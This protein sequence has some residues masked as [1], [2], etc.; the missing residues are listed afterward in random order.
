MFSALVLVMRNTDAICI[1]NPVIRVNTDLIESRNA[2]NS[3]ENKINLTTFSLQTLWFQIAFPWHFIRTACTVNNSNASND[4]KNELFKKSIII[5]L[6]SRNFI[7]FFFL[8]KLFVKLFKNNFNSM[9]LYK[10]LEAI[11]NVNWEKKLHVLKIGLNQVRCTLSKRKPGL[12]YIPYIINWL[13]KH[14]YLI[15]SSNYQMNAKYLTVIQ[16]ISL[17]NLPR[18]RSKAGY[19][20]SMHSNII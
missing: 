4:N 2:G 3:H 13:L 16:R 18:R 8:K 5:I 12:T 19:V 9:T 11:E 6:N 14:V 1:C 10:C 7:A 20:T 17:I 15:S